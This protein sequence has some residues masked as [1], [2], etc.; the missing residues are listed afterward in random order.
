M[1]ISDFVPVELITI[2]LY[3]PNT[4]EK[5]LNDDGSEMTIE[6]HGPE[7]DRFRLETHRLKRGIMRK[8]ADKKKDED[9]KLDE[10]FADIIENSANFYASVAVSWNITYSGSKPKLTKEKAEE[11]FAKHKWIVDQIER[12]IG[13]IANF[14]TEQSKS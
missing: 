6:L 2:N 13:R 9:A 7:T 14:T 10:T 4:H 12:G 3:N 8:Y 5:L 11:V 1:D